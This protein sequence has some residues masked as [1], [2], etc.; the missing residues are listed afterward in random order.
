MDTNDKVEEIKIY[1]KSIIKNKILYLFTNNNLTKNITNFVNKINDFTF[2]LEKP[3]YV[4]NHKSLILP[5]TIFVKDNINL[6][7]IPKIPFIEILPLSSSSLSSNSS[8]T[9]IFNLTSSFMKSTKNNNKS[10]SSS[11]KRMSKHNRK[12]L[13]KK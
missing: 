7:N 13:K 10:S 12:Q 11:K 4:Y 6:L 1:N 3:Y 2:I 8:D 9:K 5:N